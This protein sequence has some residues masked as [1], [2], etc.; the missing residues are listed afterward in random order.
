MAPLFVQ[1]YVTS[2]N[3]IVINVF[4]LSRV[5]LSQLCVLLHFG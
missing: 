3:L 5:S 1:S 2:R 4:F